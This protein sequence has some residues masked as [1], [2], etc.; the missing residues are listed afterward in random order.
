LKT[1]FLLS[2][3]LF[4]AL[5]LS[6]TLLI[7]S[8]EEEPDL[9]G[10]NLQP[11]NEILSLSFSDTS[12]IIAY[13]VIDDS[14]RTDN[15]LYNLLGSYNDPVFGSTS[16]SIFTQVRLSDNN[17][18]FG[19]T[20]SFDSLILFMP[21]TGSYVYNNITEKPYPINVKVYE[22]AEKMSFDSTYYSY[23]NLSYKPT[24]LANVT[25]VPKPKDSTV[26]NG[27]KFPPLLILKLNNVLGNKL[28]SALPSDLTDNDAFTKF[29]NG[30]YIKTMPLSTTNTN[31]G[32]ILYF[33]LLNSQLSNLVLYYKKT[34]TDTVSSKY[35]FVINDKCTKYTHFNHYGY[36]SANIDFKNQL[37]IGVQAD[38]NLGKQKLYLQSMGGVKVKLKFPYLRNWI[39]DKKIIINEATIIIKNADIDDKNAP[40]ALLAMLKR[41]AS[42]KT[43]LLPDYDIEGS[44]FYDGVYNSTSKEYRIRITRYFQNMLNTTDTDFGL[45]L[46]VDS[47]RTSGNRLVFTGTDKS[48]TNRMKL[49]LRYTIV[50]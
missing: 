21:Y 8:C 13:S 20:P 33:N 46:L 48:L 9:I 19:N 28:L 1:Q 27:S 49:E 29:L 41:I 26:F 44:S 2:N 10:L 25:F 17:V 34:P 15:Y 31:K 38:T 37:G 3:R 24:E 47:R 16:A 39:K 40:P 30:I 50:R 35:V 43:E 18:S 5:I 4:F 7:S 11:Q 22:V 45:Y 42:G 32:S 14:M 12:S 6:V 23:S 36:G